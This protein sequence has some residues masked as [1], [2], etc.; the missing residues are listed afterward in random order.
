MATL[1]ERGSGAPAPVA[2]D[3]FCASGTGRRQDCSNCSRILRDIASAALREAV[4]GGCWA[5]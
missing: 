5:K 1:S 3:I 2:P 4:S